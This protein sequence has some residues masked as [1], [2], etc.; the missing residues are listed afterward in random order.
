MPS[1][2][3]A[4]SG[5]VGVARDEIVLGVEDVLLDEAIGFRVVERCSG[6]DGGVDGHGFPG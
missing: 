3:Y 1:L 4:R 2:L 5:T 6:P